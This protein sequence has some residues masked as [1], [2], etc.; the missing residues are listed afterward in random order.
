M[1]YVDD[2]AY[3]VIALITFNALLVFAWWGVISLYSRT[4]ECR[5]RRC[6]QW[7]KAW[8][9]LECPDNVIELPKQRRVG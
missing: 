1:T 5:A 8:G 9:E 4:H 7:R 3:A 2:A 6:D